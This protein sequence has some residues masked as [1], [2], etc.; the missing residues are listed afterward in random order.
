MA[1]LEARRAAEPV[2]DDDEDDEPVEAI[3]VPDHGPSD[4]EI[5]RSQARLAA[6]LAEVEPVVAADFE[7]IA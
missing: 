7:Q 5:D 2:E 4:A 6:V 1:D 3:A